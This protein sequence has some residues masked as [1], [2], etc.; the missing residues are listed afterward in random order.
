MSKGTGLWSRKGKVAETVVSAKRS[1]GE[2]CVLLHVICVT[3]IGK[4]SIVASQ[5]KMLEDE[6]NQ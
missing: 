4:R 5:K 3:D 6:C 1:K 2:D